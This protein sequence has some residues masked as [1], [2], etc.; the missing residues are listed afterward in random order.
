[1]SKFTQEKYDGWKARVRIL[2]Q[3]KTTLTGIDVAKELGCDYRTGLRILKKVE[4]E[5][6][7]NLRRAVAEDDLAELAEFIK[8]A[9]PELAAIVFN[10]NETPK[11]KVIAY[12]AMLEG[13]SKAIDLKMDAGIYQRN[14]GKLQIAGSLT[15]EDKQ[16]L[17]IALAYATDQAN[18]SRAS[19]ISGEQDNADSAS[20]E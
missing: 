7:E 8:Q 20:A 1:M 16:L 10:P 15:A 2:L 13:K 19:R 9:N 11:N 14:L 17:E 3:L 12:R 6:V 5:R 4:R 18:A